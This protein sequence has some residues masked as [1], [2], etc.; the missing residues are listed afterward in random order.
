[1]TVTLANLNAALNGLVY[2]PKSG[3]SGPDSL[4]IS[5][6]DSGDNLTGSATVA[7]AVNPPPQV[8][9]PS[10]ANV[11]QN[12]SVTFSTAL[13][14]AITVADISATPASD[15]LTLTVV[16]GTLTLA[17]TSGLA[18]QNGTTNKSALIEVIGTLANVN[19]ALNG[20]VYTPQTGYAG[21]DSL[22]ISVTDQTDVLNGSATVA[23]SVN[24]VPVAS[25]GPNQTVSQG[26]AVS[27]NGSVTYTSVPGATLSTVWQVANGPGTV[28]FGNSASPQ[29]TAIF[30]AAGT[31]YLRLVA[32][33]GGQ[34]DQSYVTI[35]VDSVS[36][37]STA[38]LQQGV[39]SYTRMTDTRRTRTAVVRGFGSS[40]DRPRSA[41]YS[42]GL[43]CG[44]S[45]FPSC[46]SLLPSCA[47]SIAR[48]RNTIRKT[49]PCAISTRRP[50]W[51]T[52]FTQSTI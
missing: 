12:G 1:M 36:P 26:A 49:A 29:T 11:S 39:N 19:A 20:L 24:S 7:I 45:H 46:R 28:T 23:I 32:T 31:Y 38:K 52:R 21:P 40:P 17:S 47:R 25:A 44:G 34:T 41:P 4:Q 50:R 43:R 51:T 35:T 16:N 2:T 8:T 9:A 15:S 5:V 13:G 14:D 42:T 33:Y 10:S 37:P 27:L 3:Y 22:G 18:F 30:S 6:K 48:R